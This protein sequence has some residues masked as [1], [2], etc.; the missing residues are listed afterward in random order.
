MVTDALS[1]KSC[2]I[3]T[4]AQLG[5][6][7]QQDMMDLRKLHVDLQVNKAGVLLATINVKPILLDRIKEDQDK[8]PK[9]GD[10][11]KRIQQ[12]EKTA[13]LQSKDGVLRLNGRIC[14]P[15]NDNLRE[16]ILEEAHT[17]PHAMHS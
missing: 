9:C 4:E 12:G 7:R 8:D 10:L 15:R 16:E 1:Q 17:A 6:I 13:F 5:A 11:M 3:M 2:S 14:V